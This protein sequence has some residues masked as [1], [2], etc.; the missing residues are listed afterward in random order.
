M[1]IGKV[2]PGTFRFFSKQPQK[3]RTLRGS[4]DF[5]ETAQVRDTSPFDESR[6]LVSAL[7]RTE[8]KWLC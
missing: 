5:G 3:K 2:D 1:K 8:R 6:K 7:L 4:W